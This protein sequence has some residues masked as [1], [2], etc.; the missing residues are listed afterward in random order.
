L[1]HL[2]AVNRSFCG[3]VDLVQ[4]VRGRKA[5]GSLRATIATTAVATITARGA[6]GD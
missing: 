4:I 3:T 6:L 1:L 2:S 5:A